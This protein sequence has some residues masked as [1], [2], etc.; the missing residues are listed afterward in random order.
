MKIIINE[1]TDCSETEIIINCKE[2]DSEI[3]KLLASL[4]EH[5][6]KLTGI[7]DGKTYV[8]EPSSVYYFD[9]V[10]KKIFIYTKDN[11]LETDLRLYTLEERLSSNHFFRASKSTIINISKIKT[12]VP[13]FGGRLEVTLQNNEKLI[14][15]RQYAHELKIKLGL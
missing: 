2:A 13:D 8:V 9:T 4:K 15:S 5:E 11:V 1:N 3:L 10:D 6:Q 14:V 7:K 12:I